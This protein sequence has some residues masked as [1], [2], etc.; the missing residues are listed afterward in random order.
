MEKPQ[1]PFVFGVLFTAALVAVLLILNLFTGGALL[2]ATNLKII[3]S[4]V[5]YPAFVAWGINFL[6][7]CGYTDL[8]IGGVIVLSAFAS[9]IFGNMY[10]YP[11]VVLGGLIVGTLLIFI[12]F[13]IFA[14]TKIPS[15]IAGISLAMIYEAVAVFLKMGDATKNLVVTDLK[16][17]YRALGQLPLSLVLLGVGLVVC[18]FLYNRTSVGL[19]IRAIG[20]NEHVAKSLGIN[21][22]R[23]LLWLG[24]ISG[25]LIGIAS[26]VQISFSGRMTVKTGLTSMYLMFQP[27]A[28]VLLAQVMQKRINIIIAIPICSFIV[29]V[30][31]SFLT[32][33]GVPSG[34]LQEA[35]LGL[36]LIVFGIL[37]QRGN[38][39]VVK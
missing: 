12:N 30:V 9:T 18:Y 28:I 14:W 23:T 17:E 22:T 37:G 15:W 33:M 38:K 31:F 29:D 3:A 35:S 5:V 1:N 2:E 25:I 34:T 39:G 26:I 36:F 19:N 16:T 11:G 10:G 7:A 8:S 13:N 32:H 27:L 4:H 24:L 6:F 21:I 20:G